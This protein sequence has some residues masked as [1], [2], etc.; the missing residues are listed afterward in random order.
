MLKTEKKNTLSSRQA[1]FV[2]NESV[3]FFS[4][5]NMFWLIGFTSQQLR[6]LN[7]YQVFVALNSHTT[8]LFVSFYWCAVSI[9]IC[10]R[11]RTARLP[12]QRPARAVSFG[13]TNYEECL[14]R[15]EWA[16]EWVSEWVSE[17]HICISE[18]TQQT[19]F[20]RFAFSTRLKTVLDHELKISIAWWL[21]QLSGIEI[22][23]K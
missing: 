9:S 8:S 6:Y 16:S 11:A 10:R 22:V 20:Q 7:K 13:P 3:V 21:T 18:S 1:C 23:S 4:I 15:S 5:F 17:W 19:S 12:F 14:H 2:M